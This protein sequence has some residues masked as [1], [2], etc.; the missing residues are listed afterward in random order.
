[1]V[2]EIAPV[3]LAA[4]QMAPP[5]AAQL[6]VNDAMPAGIG[7][8]RTE[9]SAGRLLT[10]V[11][12]TVY[13]RLPPAV[14]VATLT[15]FAM[16]TIGAGLLVTVATHGGGV[17]PGSHCPPGGSACAV[18]TMDAGGAAATVASTVYSRTPPG[19]K[20]RSRFI[21]RACAARIRT[22]GTGARSARPREGRD[23]GGD[24]IGDH[25]AGAIGGSHVGDPDRIGERSTWRRSRGARGLLDRDRGPRGKRL[26]EANLLVLRRHPCGGRE[27]EAHLC[28]SYECG[29]GDRA[30]ASVDP[31]DPVR[32]VDELQSPRIG[33]AARGVVDHAEA[34]ALASAGRV[35]NPARICPQEAAAGDA[36]QQLVGRRIRRPAADHDMVWLQE[37]GR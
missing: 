5:A 23:S 7:S 19:G 3:P 9:P 2:C 32:D 33:H 31:R 35:R 16:S 8:V 4:G 29:T 10:L 21:D 22:S 36:G 15:D 6:H 37:R 24:R 12:V 18:F 26:H 14:M 30:Q 1:M 34:H 13:V 17:S 27:S 20:R 25:R 11:A 28:R